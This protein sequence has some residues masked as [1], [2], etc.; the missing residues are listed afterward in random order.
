MGCTP[1]STRLRRSVSSGVVDF[2]VGAVVV[3][4]GGVAVAVVV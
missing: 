4:G 2:V 1:D 3:V